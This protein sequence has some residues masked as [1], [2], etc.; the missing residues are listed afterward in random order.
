MPHELTPSQR[1]PGVAIE[2]RDLVK[3]YGAKVVA[4]DGVCLAVPPASVFAMLGPN[5]AGKSTAVRILTTLARPDSGSVSVCGVD[6]LDQPQAVRRIIGV[7]GQ[8]C[9]SDPQATGRENLVL[10]G[11]IQGLHG[12]VLHSRVDQL[13]DSLGI[14]DAADRRVRTW[15][16]GMRRRL[17]IAMGVIHQP[18][19]LFLDEPTTGLD[20]EARAEVWRL[21]RHLTSEASVTIL[22]TTH[23]LEEADEFA[24]QL[25][26][27][28]RGRIVTT[29]S[30]DSLK[31]ELH[32]DALRLE[33]SRDVSAR[34]LQ[35]AFRCVDGMGDISVSGRLV[36]A[37]VSDGA[38]ITP[39]ALAALESA[40]LTV[41]SV[42]ISRP[43]LADVY[44]RHTGYEFAAEE[45]PALSRQAT[46]GAPI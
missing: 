22:L 20:P 29:G 1:H 16:G 32:G 24:D 12:T 10:Q 28:D 25:A 43:S 13:L 2:A 40:G 41:A 36:R 42:T 19:V 11:V 6:A 31:R 17:D 5:G 44:L 33:F 8:K 4:L 7:V 26:I 30:P 18:Q 3:R 9:G 39:T 27:L 45:Q 23:Y 37:R 38:A 15:S 21:V 14:A 46:A 34:E 35:G